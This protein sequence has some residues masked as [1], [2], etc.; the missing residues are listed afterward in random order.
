MLLRK[1]ITAIGQVLGI[2]QGAGHAS[3]AQDS[4]TG[5]SDNTAKVRKSASQ[6]SKPKRS[7]VKAV[8]TAQSP[9]IETLPV[10]TRTKKSST[11]GTQPATPVPPSAQSKRNSKRKA[12]KQTTAV[13]SSS[14]GKQSA[15]AVAGGRGKQ[16]ATPVRRTRQH[17]K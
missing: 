8:I 7:S 6:G 2:T 13:K 14:K 10:P 3:Q 15:Q 9:K 5:G 17:A 11:T 16:S 1:I 4:Q 12:V